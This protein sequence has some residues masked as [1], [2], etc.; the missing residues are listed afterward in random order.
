MDI[1]LIKTTDE[2]TQALLDTQIL[3]EVMKTV[4]T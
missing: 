2:K 3:P 4:Y 1:F